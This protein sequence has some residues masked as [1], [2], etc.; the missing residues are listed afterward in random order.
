ML[1]YT[2]HMKWPNTKDIKKILTDIFQACLQR[3]NKSKYDFLLTRNQKRVKCYLQSAGRKYQPRIP[4]VA[5][6]SFKNEG[7]S[8]TFQEKNK[9]E[10]TATQRKGDL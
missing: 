2:H 4:V 7:K 3:T 6:I 5:T 9:M 10:R 8:K 1:T